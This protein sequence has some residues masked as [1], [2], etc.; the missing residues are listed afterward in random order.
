[1][2]VVMGCCLSSDEE[3]T[4]REPLAQS[5]P[6][7]SW[8]ITMVLAILTHLYWSAV[9]RGKTAQTEVSLLYPNKWVWLLGSYQ[10]N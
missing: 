9:G 1:M 5:Q 7:Y 8:Y 2:R 10:D 6:K 3:K 4:D